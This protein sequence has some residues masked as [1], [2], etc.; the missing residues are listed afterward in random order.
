MVGHPIGGI[1]HKPDLRL[2]F[3]NRQVDG[4]DYAGGR[5]SWCI[6][7]VL[8]VLIITLFLVK[9]ENNVGNVAQSEKSPQNSQ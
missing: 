8:V 9:E 6:Y 3:D 1:V 4:F 5:T 2:G 7:E